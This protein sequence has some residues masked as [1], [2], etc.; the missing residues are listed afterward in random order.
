MTKELNF[1]QELT[2][3]F[4]QPISE[5]PTQVM[6]EAAYRHHDLDWRSLTI[7]VAPDGSEV[8]VKCSEARRIHA[9]QDTYGTEYRE[10][11]NLFTEA[12]FALR[13]GA[14]WV[15]F[16]IIGPQGDKAWSNPFDLR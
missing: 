16:E 13:K 2:A 9:V 12:T 11:G 7:E 8:H 1:K 5:N 4:G 15:R 6:V 14:R 3:A 10:G